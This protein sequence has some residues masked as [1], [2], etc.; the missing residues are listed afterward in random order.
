MEQILQH[1]NKRVYVELHECF[2]HWFRYYMCY[3]DMFY[4][5]KYVKKDA[6]SNSGTKIDTLF[7]VFEILTFYRR[8][9]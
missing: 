1:T 2:A 6:D 5:K 4:I 7:V 3:M 8:S 9:V